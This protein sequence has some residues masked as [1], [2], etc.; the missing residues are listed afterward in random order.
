[1]KCTQCGYFN[2]P[3]ALTCG[4]CGMDLAHPTASANRLIWA[5]ACI[6]AGRKGP[7]L[8]GSGADAGSVAG[9]CPNPTPMPPLRDSLRPWLLMTAAVLPGGGHF[10]AAGL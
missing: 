8:A 3:N 7:H 10:S 2:L 5:K 1:M 9:S 4:R 6:R